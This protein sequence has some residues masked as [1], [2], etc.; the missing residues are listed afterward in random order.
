MFVDKLVKLMLD[1]IHTNGMYWGDV[2]W[3]EISIQS[4]QWKRF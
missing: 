4:R 1:Y 3:Q 2:Y